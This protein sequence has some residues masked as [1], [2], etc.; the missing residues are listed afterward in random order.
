MKKLLNILFLILGLSS[1]AKAQ[2]DVDDV[3]SISITDQLNINYEKINSYVFE[4]CFKDSIE[5]WH[6]KQIT[7]GEFYQEIFKQQTDSV[8][9]SSILKAKRNKNIDSLIAMYEK[10][11]EFLEN[12]YL[13]YCDTVQPVFIKYIPKDVIINLLEGVQ[14]SVY[15]E[16]I[17][18]LEL[19]DKVSYGNSITMTSYYPLFGMTICSPTDTLVI[20]NYGQQDLMLPW[21]NKTK[22]RNLYNPKINWSL[23]AI[24]PKEMSYN[25]ERLVKGLSK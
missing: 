4:I 17:F 13:N 1:I 24:I 11:R 15:D 21:W 16:E 9:S 25:R 14:D 22:K 3:S 2:I 7:R 19:N 23:Y 6:T 10:R 18:L 20:F 5:L 8:Y 12:A